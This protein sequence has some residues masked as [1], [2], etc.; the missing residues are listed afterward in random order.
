MSSINYIP[1][2]NLKQYFLCSIQ[3]HQFQ[4]HS[5]II[6]LDQ[7]P[8][9]IFINHFSLIQL[10]YHLH[11]MMIFLLEIQTICH[12]LLNTWQLIQ[13]LVLNLFLIDFHSVS[14]FYYYYFSRLFL[15]LIP[16]HLLLLL[17]LPFSL[18]FPLGTLSLLPLLKHSQ[19]LYLSHLSLFFLFQ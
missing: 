18:C 1:Q 3:L 2:K 9:Y 12:L 6:Y 11:S 10:L 8:Q 4:F 14:L 7:I 13:I 5:G 16:F 15:I 17:L 19:F